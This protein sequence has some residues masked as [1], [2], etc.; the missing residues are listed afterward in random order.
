MLMGAD[1]NSVKIS[2]NGIDYVQF[3]DDI[4]A[5]DIQDNQDKKLTVLARLNINVWAGRTTVQ[6]F[7]EDYEFSGNNS[8][9]DF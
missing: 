6:C 7:I 5:A 8:K 1:K 4:F 2:Y 3:K 9:Y